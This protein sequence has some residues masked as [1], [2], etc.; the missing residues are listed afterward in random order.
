MIL[1]RITELLLDTGVVHT[2]TDWEVS[3]TL[4]FAIES[5]VASSY[6]DTANISGITF[7]NDLDP[8]VKYYAR[9]RVL[10]TTGYTIW[11][12]IDVMTPTYISNLD[13][14]QEAPSVISLPIVTSSSDVNNHSNSLFTLTAGGYSAY[15]TA[16]LESTSWFIEDALGNVVWTSLDNK[17]NKNTIFVGNIVLKDKGLYRAYA[18]FNSSSGDKSMAGTVTFVTNNVTSTDV[19]T[20][21]NALNV[22]TVLKISF[23]Y[24]PLVTNIYA[25]IDMVENNTLSL[26][27]DN[28]GVVTIDSSVGLITYT[29]PANT[30]KISKSYFLSFRTNL[31]NNISIK[32]FTTF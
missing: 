6:A 20:N 15:G 23:L 11:G 2:A 16:V 24:N 9:A 31:E 28:T 27:H 13:I 32:Q 29:I 4:D 5:I 18:I 30:L 17:V 25:R 7:N 26:I 22:A 14:I 10:L 1:L 21:L 3:T 19:L 12:N 8:N